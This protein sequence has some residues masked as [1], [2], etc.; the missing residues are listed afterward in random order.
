MALSSLLARRLSPKDQAALED[1]PERLQPIRD[2]HD[3]LARQ[4]A[5]VFVQSVERYVVPKVYRP[6]RDFILSMDFDSE[7]TGAGWM[8]NLLSAEDFQ[9]NE[10]LQRKANALR[11]MEDSGYMVQEA[12]GQKGLTELVPETADKRRLQLDL[13][14][15]VYFTV[16]THPLFVVCHYVVYHTDS[17]FLEDSEES[18]QG[19]H[20][21]DLEGATVIVDARSESVLALLM[22]SHNE[23]RQETFSDP[24]QWRYFRSRLEPQM[25]DQ[26]F[27]ETDEA[28]KHWLVRRMAGDTV[29]SDRPLRHCYVLSESG[30]HAQRRYRGRPEGASIVY[31]L[32][33]DDAHRRPPL[34]EDAYTEDKS[35]F[36]LVPYRL[37]YIGSRRVLNSAMWTMWGAYYGVKRAAYGMNPPWQWAASNHPELDR[38]WWINPLAFA[39]QK[40]YRP[41]HYTCNPY[42]LTGRR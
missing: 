21:G 37:V 15:A 13:R 10:I 1:P 8:R 28:G 3:Q 27:S 24:W 12:Q 36:P 2:L 39:F 33:K 5:P 31:Y 17:A 6:W 29:L 16:L 19:Y 11:C 35:D 9:D 14:P 20:A 25:A 40:S 32:D 4:Y 30:M 18:G 41:E 23:V 34:E 22:V 7:W 26:D 38:P 42:G